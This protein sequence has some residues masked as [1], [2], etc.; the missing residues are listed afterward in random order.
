MQDIIYKLKIVVNLNTGLCT[1]ACLLERGWGQECQGFPNFGSELQL[2]SRRHSMGL[3]KTLAQFPGLA[4]SLRRRV[5]LT[6][7]DMQ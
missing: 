6:L 1:G 5:S 3:Q 4:R 7:H 2:E